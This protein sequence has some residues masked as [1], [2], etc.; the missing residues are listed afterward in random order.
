MIGAR[1]AQPL[2]VAALVH[3]A[4]LAVDRAVDGADPGNGVSALSACR[5]FA[6]IARKYSMV[7]A[8]VSTSG[9]P[10]ISVVVPTRNRAEHAVACARAL[11]Q[12][13]GLE[14]VLFVDQSDDRATE[15]GLAALADSRVRHVPSVLRGATNGRNVGIDATTGAVVAFTDDDCRVA[16]DWL[17]RIADIFRTDK[18]AA[19]VCGRVRLPDELREQGF[20]IEF[21][22]KV[23]YYHHRFPPPDGDWGITANLS[24]RREVFERL[25]KFDPFLGPGAPLL[26]GEEP[27]LLFRVLSAGLKVVNASEVEVLHLGI[28]A[29]GRESSQLWDTYGVGTAAA[30]FK[31][32]RLGDADAARLYLGHLA[33]MGRIITKN[34]FSGR[35]PLGLRYTLSFLSGTV[36]SLRFR[37]DRGRQ[38]YTRP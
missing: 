6:P 20:A 28:R 35:R 14:E 33:N 36:A 37:I 26:C 38:L 15:L 13:R 9:G 34:L 22:P 2:V 29:F 18:D 12:C 30:L 7:A 8:M 11:L 31:H 21:E 4:L 32:V 24:A 19:V 25:G 1:L 5:T 17:E 10:R 27:D 23:R 16:P 3:T